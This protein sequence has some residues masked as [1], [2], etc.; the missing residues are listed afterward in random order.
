VES[1]AVTVLDEF[2]DGDRYAERHVV[3]LRKR[4]GSRIRQEVYA[5]AQCDADGRFACIEEMSLPLE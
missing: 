5:F 3:D 2:V 1:A 4:D